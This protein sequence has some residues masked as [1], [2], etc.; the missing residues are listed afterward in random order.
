MDVILQEEMIGI[1]T[2]TKNLRYSLKGILA[3]LASKSILLLI[4]ECREKIAFP[5]SYPVKGI[6]S[7]L[8]I[9]AFTFHLVTDTTF[10]LECFN[11]HLINIKLNMRF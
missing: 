1:S 4:I 9:T 3:I 6:S 2:I 5:S 11:F 7:W 10:N 8:I